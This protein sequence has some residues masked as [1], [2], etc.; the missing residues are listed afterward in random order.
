MRELSHRLGQ[1][2][3][4]ILPSGITKIETGARRVNVDDLVALAIVL[5]VVPNRILLD[6]AA[7]D[8]LISLTPTVNVPR[9]RAW[10][11]VTGERPLFDDDE[12]RRDPTFRT[13]RRENRP[14]DSDPSGT[15]LAKLMAL[16]QEYLTPVISAIHDVLEN[17]DVTFDKVIEY[18]RFTYAVDEA[19]RSIID[20]HPDNQE[21]QPSGGQNRAKRADG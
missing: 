3:Q 1:I 9:R 5:R 12:S 17:E 18:L 7:D 16:G 15:Q 11:W 19:R 10:N 8:E 4:P 13:F 14:A 6:P 21:N 20:A 2:G